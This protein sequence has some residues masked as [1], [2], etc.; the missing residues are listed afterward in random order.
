MI[1]FIAFYKNGANIA[2]S[3]PKDV[4]HWG[5]SVELTAV[6]LVKGE[7]KSGEKAFVYIMY[8]AK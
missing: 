5:Q 2:S 8:K 6:I 1:D 3:F 4:F 7:L